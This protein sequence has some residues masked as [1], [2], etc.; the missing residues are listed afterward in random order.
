MSTSAHSLSVNSH[1]HPTLGDILVLLDAASPKTQ[2]HRNMAS[3][4]RNLCK[5]AGREPGKVR[6]QS[7]EMRSAFQCSAWGAFGFTRQRWA[8][9]RSDVKRAIRWSGYENTPKLSR[10]PLNDPWEAVISPVPHPMPKSMLC[11]F[12]RF[13]SGLQ[14]TPD[15]VTDVEVEAFF[16]NLSN[17]QCSKSPERITRDTIRFWNKYIYPLGDVQCL[18][19][20]GTRDYYGL[21]WDT[22]PPSFLKDATA[23][24]DRTLNA[25][26]MDEDIR[27]VRPATAK[28]RHRQLRRLASAE[29]LGG[30]SPHDIVDLNALVQP[31]HLQKGME[32]LLTRNNKQ[33]NRQMYDL[34]ILGQTVASHWVQLDPV[35]LHEIRKWA[36][37]IKPTKSGMTEGNRERM[38][39]LKDPAIR[40][41]LYDLP[42]A[43]VK[44][45]LKMPKT[46]AAAMKLQ[47]GITIGILLNAPIRLQ[48]L[49][50]LNWNCHFAYRYTD[51]GKV[52]F[53][54]LPA[55]EVKN[56]QDIELPLPDWIAAA[57][58]RYVADYIPLITEQAETMHLL[59]GPT[60]VP[61][62]ESGARSLIMRTIKREL[63]LIINPHLFR[64]IAAFTF[65]SKYPGHYETVRKLLGHKNIQTTL[66][67][68]TGLEDE[69]AIAMFGAMIEDIGRGDE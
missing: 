49:R 38:E 40:E 23:F 69:A 8:N 16:Q 53:L 46:Y 56:D 39:S 45:A 58:E 20:R 19:S 68:Y 43:L 59:P 28:Q 54:L 57:I 37:K 33:P 13:C 4:V 51:K 31:E 29:V 36:K 66:N 15:S 52:L 35:K 18:S 7:P 62:S 5:V 24:Q 22:F 55:H 65:L 26:F 61:K 48:N 50:T 1:S 14:V 34:L 64:H 47:A 44:S 2:S 10:I 11:R 63:G 17:I 41:R 42:K 6:L 21:P 67:F 25:N 27:L 12:G 9:I 60:G 3:S 30:V 32:Y